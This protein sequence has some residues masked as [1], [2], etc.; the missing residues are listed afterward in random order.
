LKFRL[1]YFGNS[2]SLTKRDVGDRRSVSVSVEKEFSACG[3]IAPV[4]GHSGMIPRISLRSS[5]LRLL[6]PAVHEDDRVHLA[7]SF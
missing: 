3:T 1:P 4:S 2:L 5:G 7:G 6:K